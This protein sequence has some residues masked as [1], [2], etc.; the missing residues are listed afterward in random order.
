MKHA[1][2]A[3]TDLVSQFLSPHHNVR[4]DEWGG[5]ATRRMRF[6]LEVYR[7]ICDAVGDDYPVGIKLNSADFH[8]G[9]FSQDESVRVV[10]AL[11]DAGIDLVEIS[12][13]TYETATMVD[14]RGAKEGSARSSSAARATASSSA[15]RDARRFSNQ[16]EV[17]LRHALETASV[18]ALHADH[19][20][21]GH[22]A[23]FVR[24]RRADQRT[25]QLQVLGHIGRWDVAFDLHVARHVAA[26]QMRLDDRVEDFV[27]ITRSVVLVRPAA[28]VRRHAR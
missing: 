10:A 12:G 15:G 28:V 21:A 4:D 19:E 13:G 14:G 9:G 11:A 1:P 2:S 6:V 3:Q 24:A 23:N 25:K 26:G 20:A 7:A 16:R 8:R 27:E 5:D 22:G 18:R 17:A